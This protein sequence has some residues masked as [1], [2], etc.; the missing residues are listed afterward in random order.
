MV[1]T[2]FRFLRDFSFF[3]GHIWFYSVSLGLGWSQV[4]GPRTHGPPVD[5]TPARTDDEWY[6]GRLRL[7]EF[8]PVLLF[9][10]G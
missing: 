10:V 6:V 7:R 2:L 9:R 8:L 3:S 5:P 1:V 4:R